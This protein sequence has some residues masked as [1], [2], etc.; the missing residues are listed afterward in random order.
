MKQHITLEQLNELSDKGKKKLHKYF[1]DN[2]VGLL[3]VKVIDFDNLEGLITIV[4]DHKDAD[5]VYLYFEYPNYFTK[6]G[7]IRYQNSCVLPLL[8]IGQMIEFLDGKFINFW[9]GARK[10]WLIVIDD[11]KHIVKKELCDALWQAVKKVLE[12]D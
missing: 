2:V 1:Y 5:L 4:D 8:S 11:D 7:S 10:D 9:R 12:N 3:P 6:V